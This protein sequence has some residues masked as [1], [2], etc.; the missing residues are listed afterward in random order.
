MVQAGTLFG[1]LAAFITVLLAIA[2]GDM[3]VS[4]HRLLRARRRI[5]WHPLPLVAAFIVLLILLTNF[6]AIW[7]LTETERI[8]FLELCWLLVPQ[9]LYF[10]AASAVLPDE[11]PA[12][13]LNLFDFYAAERRY[14]YTLLLLAVVAEIIDGTLRLRLFEQDP[15]R[16]FTHY[17]PLNFVSSL[18][19]L[20]MIWRREKWVH[21]T[22]LTILLVVAY[23]GVL[24]W[25]VEGAAAIVPA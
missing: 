18:S 6:F 10:L 2:V 4:L 19:L 11:I 23:F 22:A 3:A 21:W 14:L 1:Y 8:T 5:K 25:T 7:R 13:G 9:F 12:K 15:Q 20:A 17:L 16:Y 24:G